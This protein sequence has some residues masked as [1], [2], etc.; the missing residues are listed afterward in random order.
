M[1]SMCMTPPIKKNGKLFDAFNMYDTTYKKN[2]KLF[3]AFNMYDTTHKKYGKT[4][5]W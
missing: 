4:H 2:G 5:C 3:D 1:L